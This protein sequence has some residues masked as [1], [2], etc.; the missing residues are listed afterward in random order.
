MTWRSIEGD[1]YLEIDIDG[2]AQI[3]GL[4]MI[5]IGDY[6]GVCLENAGEH[7]AGEGVWRVISTGGVLLTIDGMYWTVFPWGA[8]SDPWSRV[9]YYPCGPDYSPPVVLDRDILAE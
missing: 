6:P 5:P 1:Q 4:W 8:D 9:A 7:F 3:D 2:T